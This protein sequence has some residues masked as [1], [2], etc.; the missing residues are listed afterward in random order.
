[1]C[2]DLRIKLKETTLVAFGS[3]PF[4][5]GAGYEF[6]NDTGFEFEEE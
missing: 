6:T 4:E 1:M 2:E 3:Y 5:S